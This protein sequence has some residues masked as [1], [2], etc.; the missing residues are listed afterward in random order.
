MKTILSLLSVLS[1]AA[2][3]ADPND[4]PANSRDD[5]M[6]DRGDAYKGVDQGDDGPSVSDTTLGEETAMPAD[7]TVAK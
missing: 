5:R 2:C 3:I 6:D 1:L 7:L 4:D